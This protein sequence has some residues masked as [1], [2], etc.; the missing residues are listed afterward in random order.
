MDRMMK[1]LKMIMS[2]ELTDGLLINAVS[3]VV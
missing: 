2:G 1:D 3:D